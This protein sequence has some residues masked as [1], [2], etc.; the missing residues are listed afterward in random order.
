[1]NIWINIFVWILYGTAL[2]IFAWEIISAFNTTKAHGVFKL[3]TWVNYGI[4]GI[5]FW[6]M[7]IIN[8]ANGMLGGTPTTVGIP[9]AVVSLMASIWMLIN[10]KI[11]MKALKKVKE[12]YE[13]EDVIDPDAGII[14]R[15][16]FGVKKVKRNL[17]M[18][19]E[20]L[21]EYRSESRKR[22]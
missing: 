17:S 2:I 3:I 11:M 10:R 13:Q 9:S 1:M 8:K 6:I 20:V 18:A 19:K 4:V 14:K 15:V 22:R 16:G 21:D 12:K 5:D 7:S